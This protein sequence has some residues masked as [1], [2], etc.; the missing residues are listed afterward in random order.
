MSDD[1]FKALEQALSAHALDEMTN[2]GGLMLSDWIITAACVLSEQ[3]ATGYLHV[4]AE[5]TPAHTRL[6]LA[7]VG[8][9]NAERQWMSGGDDD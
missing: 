7:R 9:V 4:N 8:W 5:H 3:G 1:T 2:D 6:G